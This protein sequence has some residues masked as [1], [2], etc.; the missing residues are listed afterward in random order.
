[1]QK[2]LLLLT[3]LLLASVVEAQPSFPIVVRGCVEEEDGDPVVAVKVTVENMDE[4]TDRSD[5]TDESGCYQVSSGREFQLHDGDDIRVYLTY[6]GEDYE[7]YEQVGEDPVIVVDFVV[8][9][10]PSY[11]WVAISALAIGLAGIFLYLKY[12]PLDSNDS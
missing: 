1:M 4:G 5:T 11:L 2:V 10:P 9:E 7:E 8:E 12:H 6:G 3:L